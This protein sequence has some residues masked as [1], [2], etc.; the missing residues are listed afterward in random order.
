MS[1]TT[2]RMPRRARAIINRMLGTREITKEGLNW[3]TLATDPFHDGN[4]E[5][6]GYPDLNT[7]SSIV[8]CF[9][10]TVQVSAPGG[11]TTPTWDAHIFLNPMVT[12]ID[13]TVAPQWTT[14]AIQPKSG[15]IT[16]N[17]T[18]QSVYSGFNCITTEEGVNWLTPLAV[19]NGVFPA[20][21]YPESATGGQFRL[22][23][24]GFEVVNTTPELYKGGS[25]T[26][27]RTPSTKRVGEFYSGVGTTL[28]TTSTMT[29]GVTPPSTQAMAQLYPTSKTWSAM[30][31]A[32]SISTLSDTDNPFSR[33][34]PGTVLATSPAPYADIQNDTAATGWVNMNYASA[35]TAST[36]EAGYLLPFD[37]NGAIFAGLQPQSTLQ[38][39]VKYYVERV[40]TIT[41]PDLLV[42]SRPPSPYDPMAL[43][44]YTRTIQELPVACLVKDN[45]LGEWFNDVIET[46]SDLAPVVGSAFGPVGS[47]MGTALGGLGHAVTGGKRKPPPKKAQPPRAPPRP[48]PKRRPPAKQTKPSVMAAKTKRRRST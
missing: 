21:R 35:W 18:G 33:C 34:L 8:Q 27:Y 3:L 4:V 23:A 1:A 26:V 28:T 12:P 16:R 13:Q 2:E 37:I 10:Y 25:V 15:F 17:V 42:L 44:L 6:A 19:T 5:P 32:Y 36:Q 47:A 43:E 48:Q 11:L 7:C 40:P 9:T 29:V 38:L 30:E 39:T 22:V 45:P 41:Q 24:A 14:A 20:I 46:V 31:G